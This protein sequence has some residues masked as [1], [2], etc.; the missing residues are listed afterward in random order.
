MS[1]DLT[2]TD[3]P[4][5][6]SIDQCVD[7]IREGEKPREA[8][9]L[10]LEHEKFIYP[11][12]GSNPVPYEGRQGVEGLFEALMERGYAPFREA[13]DRPV[14]A[15]TW[16]RATVSLEPGG[17][18]ELSGSPHR[19]AREAHAENLAH[20]ADAVQAA[21]G[22]GLSLV[23]LGFRPVGTNRD[24]PWMPKTRY[25]AMREELPRRGARAWD[26]MQMT[27]TGQVSLDWS[28]EAD[29]AR[30]MEISARFSP[31][32][33][34]LYANSPLKEG[35]PSGT[36]SERSRVWNEVDPTRC[37]YLPSMFDGSFSYRSYV[38]WAFEAPLLFLRR[39]G[40][41]LQPDITFGQLL[42]EGWQGER[43][44]L[45]DWQDHLSTLFPEVRIKQ[46]ME[47]RAADS[48]D[49]ELTGSLPALLRGLLYDEGSLDAL[50]QLLPRLDYQA[51]LAFHADTQVR[52]L[53]AEV[54]GHQVLPLAQEL[55]E[56]AAR[57]L[58]RLDPA[59]L[60]LLEPLRALVAEG[61]DPAQAVLDAWAR[62]P[63]AAALF[64]ELAI[65]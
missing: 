39:E 38:D 37:G 49:P 56:I 25:R 48:V 42:R 12:G 36:R 45:S 29:C 47:I 65:R 53:K 3:S 4:V 17:Q 41:Y 44:T 2:T 9:L 16:G 52:G 26:M 27:S 22:L 62:K 21:D 10:G 58:Q 51:H 6:T 46:V 15:L 31:L 61:R 14:I 33:V 60:P 8:Y 40:R 18:F 55:V 24:M 34:A 7:W 1:L 30:K 57:G 28:D 35:R 32:L 23:P 63:D 5:L 54:Q 13:P 19:T 59:D 11:T 20:L 43:A 50:E 64:Q